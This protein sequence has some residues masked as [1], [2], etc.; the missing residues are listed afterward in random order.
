[1]AL[2]VISVVVALYLQRRGWCL[3]NRGLLQRGRGSARGRRKSRYRSVNPDP[4][5]SAF[6][7]GWLPY[8]NRPD[9]CR[10]EGCFEPAT[11]HVIRLC[12]GHLV[13]Y[14]IEVPGEVL[15]LAP[16]LHQLRACG[17]RIATGLSAASRA[18]A[19]HRAPPASVP[20][21]PKA[22]HLVPTRHQP[23]TLPPVPPCAYSAAWLGRFSP[24]TDP[25][26]RGRNV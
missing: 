19:A 23:T 11:D 17:H 7:P 4:T 1:M 3:R 14:Q 8:P 18:L 25:A 22:P 15:E 12:A 6:A 21:A 2:V 20:A 5:K 10:R 13:E 16:A 9:I 24:T 26:R